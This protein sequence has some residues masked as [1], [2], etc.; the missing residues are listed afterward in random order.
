MHYKATN[1]KLKRQDV[2]NVGEKGKPQEAHVSYLTEVC[3]I[4]KQFTC[5]EF[6]KIT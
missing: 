3:V 2:F 4:E 5:E 6:C 1:K